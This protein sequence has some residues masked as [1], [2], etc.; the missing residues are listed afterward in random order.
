[1]EEPHEGSSWGLRADGRAVTERERL[2]VQREAVKIP[3]V[4]DLQVDREKIE[5]YL[6][7]A[8]HPDG[9][10]KAEFFSR[11]GFSLPQWRELADAL[12]NHGAGG[13]VVRTV[14]S[15]YGTRYAVDGPLET[16]DRRNP[17]VRTVWL[18]RQSGTARLITA[19]PIGGQR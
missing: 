10:T 18:L 2:T 17:L 5:Q 3:N 15:A 4:D 14:E 12:R 7:A 9:S 8:T 16:P 6:L 13:K 1:M 19:Y 11:F